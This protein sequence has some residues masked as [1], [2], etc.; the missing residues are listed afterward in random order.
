M[1]ALVRFSVIGPPTMGPEGGH[2]K[3]VSLYSNQA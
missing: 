2:I 3:E 1:V